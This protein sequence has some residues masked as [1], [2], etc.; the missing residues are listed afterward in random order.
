[1]RFNDHSRIEGSHAFLSASTYHWVNYDDEKLRLRLRTSMEAAR[2]TRL[3]DF[4]KSAIELKQRMP[5]NNQT[6]N[7][8]INDAIAYDM[9]PEQVL[10]YS[11]NAFGTADAIR[12][13]MDKMRLMIHDLKTGVTK[14]SMTQLEVY[15]AFF[16]LEYSMKPSELDIILR[17]YQNDEVWEHIPELENIVYIMDKIISSDQIIQEEK[18]L[19]L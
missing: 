10:F 8:Y 19:F 14:V 13:D 9:T 18:A 4:A 7:R 2:G 17:I 1:M 15:T 6:L 16:C 3:H 5:R 12:F 11:M